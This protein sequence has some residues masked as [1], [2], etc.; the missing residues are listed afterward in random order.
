[1][2]CSIFCVIIAL[3]ICWKGRKKYNSEEATSDVTDTTKSSTQPIPPPRP[4]D[5]PPLP[6]PTSLF[7]H[8]FSPFS[9]GECNIAN[10]PVPPPRPPNFSQL[11][12]PTSMSALKFPPPSNQD[13]VPVYVQPPGASERPIYIEPNKTFE[14]EPPP[15]YPEHN[16]YELTPTG[17]QNNVS[18]QTTHNKESQKDDE[19][20]TGV[21]IYNNTLGN[22][23]Y[24]NTL[25][26]PHQT[27]YSNM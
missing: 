5:L 10:Q 1:M 7:S 19:I 6:T 20:L 11:T 8:V 27:D 21:H 12:T 18:S 25:A 24:E 16:L 26:V 23:Q 2:C 4:T 15:P 14:E 13:L 17:S 9:P 3:V 22:P